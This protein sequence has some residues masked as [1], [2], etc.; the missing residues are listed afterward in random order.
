MERPKG[1]NSPGYTQVLDHTFW[2]AAS[3]TLKTPGN[4]HTLGTPVTTYF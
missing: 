1:R 2:T 3:H 4:T